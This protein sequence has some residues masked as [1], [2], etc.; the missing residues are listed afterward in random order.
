MKQNWYEKQSPEKFEKAKKKN[1][2]KRW[3]IV[4]FSF[5]VLLILLIFINIYIN[6]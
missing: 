4:Q 1:K 2:T 5:F 6:K 3:T